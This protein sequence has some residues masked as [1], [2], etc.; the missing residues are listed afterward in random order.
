M[1]EP[2][3]AADP[4]RLLDLAAR[5]RAGE[6]DDTTD[7]AGSD[8]DWYEYGQTHVAEWLERLAHN[9]GPKRSRCDVVGHDWRPK[10]DGPECLRCGARNDGSGAD[11]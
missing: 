4:A 7:L 8:Y 2:V 5:I 11:D 10:M 6:A 1:T 9:D 3:L